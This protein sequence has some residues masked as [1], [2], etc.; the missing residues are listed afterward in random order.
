MADAAWSPDDSRFRLAAMKGITLKTSYSF[1]GFGEYIAVPVASNARP[2]CDFEHSQKA[3]QQQHR[4]EHADGNF[5]VETGA[6]L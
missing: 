3:A 1:H 4:R 2:L 5:H 6:G